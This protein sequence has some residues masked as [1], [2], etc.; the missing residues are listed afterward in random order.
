M[1]FVILWD[2]LSGIIILLLTYLQLGREQQVIVY[3][4]AP[5]IQDMFPFGDNKAYCIDSFKTN[6][7]ANLA[8]ISLAD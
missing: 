4:Y 5:W 1:L 3:M 6:I 2:G 8:F 7:L